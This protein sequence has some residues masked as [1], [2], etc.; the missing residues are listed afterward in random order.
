ML[1]LRRTSALFLLLVACSEEPTATDAGTRDVPASD[2]PAS[3]VPVTDDAPPVVEDA[4]VISTCD[5]SAAGD[6]ATVSGH[7]HVF[8]PPG[9]SVSGAVVAVVGDPARCAVTDDRGAYRI[10]GFAQGSSFALTM[11]HP[12]HPL[13]QTSTLTVPAEGLT[14]V[15]F[16]AP[17]VGIYRVIAQYL[18]Y[19]PDP[20][21][22]QIAATVTAVGHTGYDTGGNGEVG[23]TVS[24]DPPV[25]AS[26]GPVYF[27]YLGPSAIVPARELT[28]TTLDGGV[29]FLDVPPGRYTLRAHKEGVRFNEVTIDCRAG[30]VVN[31]APPHGLQAY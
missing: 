15:L 4:R 5:A 19:R 13:L 29:L 17:T 3:D 30:W 8:G 18:S 16:Q 2:V 9:G 7:A 20:T 6:G 25:P 31:A 10:D 26:S 14:H 12:N 23:A 1:R 27:R 28:A 24:I 11:D 21:R 22:C